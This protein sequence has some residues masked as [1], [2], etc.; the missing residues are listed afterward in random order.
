MQFTQAEHFL[1][2]YA[3]HLA[4]VLAPCNAID[5]HPWAW[6]AKPLQ[7][8]EEER[9]LGLLGDFLDVVRKADECC[10]QLDEVAGIT[11]TRTQHGLEHAAY[12]LAL[13]PQSAGAVVEELLT[14][15]QS[16]ANRQ[17]LAEFVGHVESFRSG[18]DQDI[19][20]RGQREPSS[21]CPDRQ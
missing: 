17:M 13:L 7:F 5:Q 10:E 20:L 8:E 14:P 4:A 21:R 9:V 16:A 12:T 3:Q 6:I 11:L 2:V 15:C 18:F 1:S 19:G